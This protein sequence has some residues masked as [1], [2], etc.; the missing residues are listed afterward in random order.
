MAS[1]T[2]ISVNGP[3]P[4]TA[5]FKS[6]SDL[7]TLL[8]V[9]GSAYT[10]GKGGWIGAVVS[11]DNSTVGELVV[12][13]NLTSAHSA[14]IPVMLPIT[15]GFGEHTLTLSAINTDTTTDEND[16]FNVVLLY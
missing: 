15:A 4:I 16:Y 9:S 7:P 11:L 1:Q 5:T 3:L 8:F 14:L 6:P 2:I 13:C 12:W 10:T